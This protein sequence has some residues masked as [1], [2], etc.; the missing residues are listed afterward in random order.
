MTDVSASGEASVSVTK[1]SDKKIKSA[2]IGSTVSIN[3]VT[4]KITEIGNGAFKG[5]KNLK[6]VTIGKNVTKIGNKAFSNC[7]K[8]KKIIVKGSKIKKVGK[9]AFSKVSKKAVAKVPKKA[10][11][12]Y[13]KLF[14]GVKV[15]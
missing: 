1:V 3:G 13:K 15:K 2:V 10:A 14:K 9:K 12:K 6:K 5:C 4:Y 11:K 7:S 8:L